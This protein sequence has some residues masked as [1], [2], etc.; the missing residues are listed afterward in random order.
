MLVFGGVSPESIVA[1][2]PSTLRRRNPCISEAA[3]AAETALLAPKGDMRETVR[4]QASPK[5]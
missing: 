3:E 5:E 4:W 1:Q 2:L